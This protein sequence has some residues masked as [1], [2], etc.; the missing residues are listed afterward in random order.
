MTAEPD[1]PWLVAWKAARGLP[2]QAAAPP[3]QPRQRASQGGSR[4][5]PH[6]RATAAARTANEAGFIVPVRWPNDG[7]VRR[8]PVLDADHTPPRVV[9]S[10]GWRTCIKCGSPFFSDDVIRLRL[11]DGAEGC[12]D[13]AK[14]LRIIKETG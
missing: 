14:P 8:E 2:L 9:R 1:E 13:E 11:C 10:V 4:R 5:N 6:T 7:G 3:L 12:R